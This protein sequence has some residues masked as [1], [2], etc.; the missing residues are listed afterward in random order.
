MNIF[1][2]EKT[3]EYDVLNK[4]KITN[5]E[6]NYKLEEFHFHNPGE[7]TI[8]SEEFPLELHFVFKNKKSIYV[9]G[10]VIKLHRK[11]SNILQKIIKNKIFNFPSYGNFF[12]YAGSLTTS[13]FCVNVNWNVV[14][15]PLKINESDLDFLKSKSKIS[16]ELQPR[17]GRE[18]YLCL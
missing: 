15:K 13:N 18:Y 11:T 2:N 6:D 10:F 9:I 16:R 5:N 17:R 12:S 1:F 14:E 8:N 7:H 4:I 3:L